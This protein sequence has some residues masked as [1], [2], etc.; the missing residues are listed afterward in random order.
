MSHVYDKL[1]F[2]DEI[3]V[4]FC[5]DGLVTRLV[6]LG[7][8]RMWYE[9]VFSCHGLCT[10]WVESESNSTFNPF[11]AYRILGKLFICAT[12]KLAFVKECIKLY[13]CT[14]IT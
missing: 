7:A 11:S 10:L 6:E 8:D 14:I 9:T 5:V 3:H 4:Y 13:A 2:R 1:C 12:T